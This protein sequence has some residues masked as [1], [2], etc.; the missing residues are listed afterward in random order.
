MMRISDYLP[1]SAAFALKNA[2][3]YPDAA[4]KLVNIEKSL[5]IYLHALMRSSEQTVVANKKRGLSQTL[6]AQ[7]HLNA[8]VWT[9]S[10]NAH[11]PESIQRFDNEFP[12]RQ[13][14]RNDVIETTVECVI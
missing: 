8:L 9:E 5:S 10:G 12:V 4:V 14:E 7:R 6:S 11:L 1:L 13:L 2:P 3:S